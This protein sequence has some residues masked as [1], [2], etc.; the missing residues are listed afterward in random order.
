METPEEQLSEKVI[1]DTEV[2]PPRG[3]PFPIVGIGAS[4][5]GLDAMTQ[6]L[7]ALPPDTGM[8]FVI[9]L[10][11]DPTHESQVSALLAP[12]TKMPVLAVTDNL[13]IAPNHVYVLPPN[14]TVVLD[15]EHLRLTANVRC[16]SGAGARLLE[17]RDDRAHAGRGVEVLV[18]QLQVE[19]VFQRGDDLQSLQRIHVQI[20]PEVGVGAD[21]VDRGFGDRGNDG[22]GVVLNGV[23]AIPQ[24]V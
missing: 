14:Y 12:V 3:N 22:N 13:K 20:E 2:N 6:L 4:A 9:I 23:Q 18:G 5:G 1:T 15:G 24:Y 11:L 7:R 10:H 16:V 17:R 8:A 19:V 21:R